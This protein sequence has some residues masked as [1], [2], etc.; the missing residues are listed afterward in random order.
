MVSSY[1]SFI[2]GL[3]NPQEIPYTHD[4]DFSKV[5]IKI[6]DNISPA[7]RKQLFLIVGYIAGVMDGFDIVNEAHSHLAT[8]LCDGNDYF[9][10]YFVTDPCL[11][12]YIERCKLV[13]ETVMES[14]DIK[15]S[16]FA[17]VIM[18]CFDAKM[19]LTP[20]HTQIAVRFKI[21]F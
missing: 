17:H 4:I 2:G 16:G 18:P 7:I 9:C 12:R 1:E 3:K 6:S 10:I 13:K 5:N 14:G 11:R 20:L 15:V 21:C 8:I 19:A